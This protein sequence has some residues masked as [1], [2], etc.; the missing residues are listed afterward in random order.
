MTKYTKKKKH[1]NKK[2][3]T[4]KYSN[5]GGGLIRFI[6]SKFSKKNKSKTQSKPK[7]KTT[8]KVGFFRRLFRRKKKTVK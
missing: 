8:K 1:S 3:T 5:K 7:S 4:K 2:Y 6:K